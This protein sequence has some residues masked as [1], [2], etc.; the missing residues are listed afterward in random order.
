[1]DNKKVI[2]TFLFLG[3]LVLTTS[4]LHFLI[5]GVSDETIRQSLRV[6][7]RF[8]FA[9]L[10]VIL[11]ARPLQQ[12]LKVS[13]TKMLV[14]NRAL[15]GSAYAGVMTAHLSLIF[16]R[17]YYEPTFNPDIIENLPLIFAFGIIFAMFITT[18]SGPRKFVGPKVWKVLHK[19]GI[20]YLSFGYARNYLPESLDK[21]DAHSWVMF[22][23]FAAILSLRMF[24]F[25]R[26]KMFSGVSVS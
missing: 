13:W 21:F 7:A 9:I 18:F 14:V 23:L 22:S 25:I 24:V 2:N 5:N 26:N 10:I 8:S 17:L 4:A 19:F 12:L 1:M 16:L 3:I 20:Y 11:V 15:I 6:S